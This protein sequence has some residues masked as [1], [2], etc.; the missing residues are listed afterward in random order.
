M[1]E[2]QMT[3]WSID[4]RMF[5]GA[6]GATVVAIPST[7]VTGAIRNGVTARPS[8]EKDSASP[9]DFGAVGDGATDDR[10]AVLAALTHAIDK[11]LPIDG[12]DRIYGVRGTTMI[13]NKVRPHIR[14][15]RLRQL[16]PAT[17]RVTLQF[18]A[19]QNVQIDRLDVDVGNDPRAGNMNSTVG[20]L[21]QGGS[22]HR[23]MNVNATGQGKVTYVRFWDCRDSL[24]ENISV[25]DGLFNDT[26]VD[27]TDPRLLVAD[28]VVQGI[29]LTDCYRCTLVNPSARSFHG[30]ATYYTQ[31]GF[32]AGNPLASTVRAFPNMRTRGICGGGNV[33]VTIVN[34]LVYDVEQAMDFSG[35]GNNWGNRNVQIIGGELV[36]CGSCGVKFAN[37]PNSCKAIGTTVRNVGFH[38]FLLT[39]Q[40]T[41]FQGIDSSFIDCECINPGY[42]DISFDTDVE[43]PGV[44]AYCG[45]YLV[46]TDVSV[47]GLIGGLVKNCRA[48]DKQGFYL[49][50]DDSPWALARATSAT[51]AEP[52]TGY[53]GTYPNAVFTTSAG[54]ETRTV[55]L[56]NGSTTVSWT[57]GLTG[58]ITH[59]F[60]KRPAAM[61][62][63]ALCDAP[64]LAGSLKPNMCEGL[65][66]Q[67]HVVAAQKGF[68]R[69]ACI[70]KGNSVQPIPTDANTAVRW[71]ISLEDTMGMHS[72]VSAPNRI[73]CPISGAYRVHGSLCFAPAAGAGGYR[74]AQLKVG[75]VIQSTFAYNH[76]EGEETVVPFDAD[77][78]VAA[79][80]Y[81]EVFAAQNSGRGVGLNRAASRLTVELIRAS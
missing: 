80:Q 3:T 53:T 73:V 70:M 26:S 4:R 21:V 31:S 28:D 19:C 37:A 66:S 65:I 9:M 39:G 29:H 34:P 10:A 7:P 44:A 45:Y 55:T 76:L 50:G 49:A 77:L 46:S 20:L 30:N 61:Q 8:N 42:N 58:N 68:Q 64:Y 67:G 51:M 75:G 35:G 56:T 79:G 5:L 62:W 57:T 74:R 48:I 27:A 60:V 52:W 33:D 43:G 47:G 16:G 14:Q 59:P 69:F 1:E 40:T 15:L 22:G 17:G 81:V 32:N 25:H 71:N 12:G 38:G 13:S 78:A 24:F 6:V 72:T 41:S 23:I 18:E 36:N 54:T 63:G 11:E 2:S